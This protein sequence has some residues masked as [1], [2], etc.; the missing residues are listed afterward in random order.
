MKDICILYS[1]KTGCPTLPTV[2]EAQANAELIVLAVNNHHLMA[3]TLRKA[4][5]QIRLFQMKELDASVVLDGKV[6]ELV[7]NE[8]EQLLEDIGQAY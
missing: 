6:S 3:F 2:E 1:S 8:I 5:L 4:L 7:V